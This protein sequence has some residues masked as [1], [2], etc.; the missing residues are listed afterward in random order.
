MQISGQDGKKQQTTQGSCYLHGCVGESSECTSLTI[1]DNT[2]RWYKLFSHQK[3]LLRM[4]Q[5][6]FKGHSVQKQMAHCTPKFC[7]A[8]V[9]RPKYVLNCCD[10]LASQI[11][12]PTSCK[13]SFQSH[14]DIFPSMWMRALLN[15]TDRLSIL[16]NLQNTAVLCLFCYQS[17]SIWQCAKYVQMARTLML[18]SLFPL[19][20]L[21]EKYF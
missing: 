18:S 6:L 9:R 19:Q 8:Q 11:V 4:S 1:E 20:M 2:L 5:A 21:A 16:H 14:I 10:C 13:R 3:K 15:C 17:D 7:L 12:L